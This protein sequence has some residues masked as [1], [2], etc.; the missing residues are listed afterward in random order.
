MALAHP[1]QSMPLT[2]YGAR[3]IDDV[4]IRHPFVLVSVDTGGGKTF[5]AIHAIARVIPDA[6]LLVL[7]TKKQVDANHWNDSIDSYN[8][9][10][11]SRVTYEVT[12]YEQLTQKKTYA[13]LYNKLF[14]FPKNHP[15]QRVFI[16]LDEGQ[17]VKGTHAKVARKLIRMSKLSSVAAVLALTATAAS[18]SIID[19]TNYLIFA[20]FYRNPT[21]FNKQHVKFL[22]D[23]YQPIVKDKNGRVD[24]GLLINPQQILA[25]LAEITVAI[26]TESLKPPLHYYEKVFEYDKATQKAYRQ[27]KKDYLAGAYESVQAAIKAQR[28]FIATHAD[29]RHAYIKQLIDNP[30]RPQTPILFF[31]AYVIEQEALT[32]FLQKNYPDFDIVRI[33]GRIRHSA[34]LKAASKPKSPKTF[35]LIQYRAGGE[36]LNA[37]WSSMTIF[38]TPTDSFQSFKQ[39][40]GRNRRA[41][42][43]GDVY[44]FRLVVDHT[45]NSHMWYDIIDN[46]QVFSKSLQT[47]FLN[48]TD[49]LSKTLPT[50]NDPATY[51][52]P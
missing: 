37:E 5:M 22:D 20:G 46:K 42:Q 29:Q 44:Q 3:L 40:M 4:L 50:R 30:H 47:Q 21:D 6:H 25:Q 48:D 38:Y 31:Y 16:I 24:M 10:T 33:D 27:I 34:A 23:Y 12:N 19:T 26:D 39:A 7:T 45:L 11:G 1:Y 9:V 36:G 28:E 49:T 35:V 15:R 14:N 52:H 18:N 41:F 17:R 2:E 43:K 8:Q 51:M 13:A 32:A